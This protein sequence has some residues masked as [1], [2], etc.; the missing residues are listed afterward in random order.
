MTEADA[1][2][3][4]SRERR[5]DGLRLGAFA[6]TSAV[7]GGLVSLLPPGA[8]DVAIYVLIVIGILGGSRARSAAEV[9]ALVTGGIAGALLVGVATFGGPAGPSSTGSLLFGLAMVAMLLAVPAAF[10]RWL[11]VQFDPGAPGQ[12]VAPVDVGPAG[13]RA[14]AS[15]DGAGDAVR[16]ASET[17]PAEP[18]R[19][20]RP[21]IPDPT[22]A[23][24]AR[25]WRIV[26]AMFGAGIVMLGAALAI[27]WA[28]T[29]HIL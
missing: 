13:E 5:S 12:G 7:F 27:V 21:P 23:P 22:P 29:Q 10:L 18:G 19:A 3:G 1:A 14:P 25:Q 17:Y 16:R 4:P 11:V 28:R 15:S 8:D 24:R 20:A 6:G 26:L 9:L 2:R